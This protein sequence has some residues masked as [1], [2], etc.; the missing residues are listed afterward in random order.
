MLRDPQVVSYLKILQEKYVMCPI[1]VTRKE[2]IR[3]L[4]PICYE[5]RNMLMFWRR[6]N[7][8]GKE[9]LKMVT[10]GSDFLVA[11]DFV[12]VI[13]IIDADMSENDTELLPEVNSVVEN[14]LSAKNSGQHQC[15]ICSKIC[16]SESDLLKNLKSKHLENL[17]SNNKSSK[18]KYS[19]DIFFLKSLVVI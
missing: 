5:L 16:L 11:D 14:L 10:C 9:F 15:H 1:V 3:K 8:Q 7:L 2:I 6:P 12:P 4:R 17:S 18:L 13:A 19:L